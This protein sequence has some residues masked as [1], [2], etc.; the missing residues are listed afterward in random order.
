MEMEEFSATFRIIA[1]AAIF[2]VLLIGMKTFSIKKIAIRI[3]IAI[4]L[5]IALTNEI[6]KPKETK[7][8]AKEKNMETP[9]DSTGCDGYEFE[10]KNN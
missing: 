5:A 1:I 10:C 2:I 8:T 7:F 4:I 3:L 9:T 6:T